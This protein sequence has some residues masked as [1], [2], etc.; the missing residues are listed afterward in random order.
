MPKSKLVKIGVWEDEIFKGVVIFGVGATRSLV[1]PY[2]L[3]PIEGCELVRIALKDHST[4]VS[5]I[6]SIALKMLKRA[7]KGLRLVVSFAD[8]NVGHTGQIYKAGNWI[9]TGKSSGCYFFKD[10][11][12][13]IWHPRNV[14]EDLW[15]SGKQVRPSDCE[16]IWMDGKHRFLYPLDEVLRKRLKPKSTASGFHP[17]EG[18][19]VPTETHK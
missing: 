16:K 17:E 2:G 9:Y 4:T 3:K 10:K 14:S 18:G 7:N 5:R 12:G 1:S 19:A 13:K 8:P 6:T 11:Q 15:R